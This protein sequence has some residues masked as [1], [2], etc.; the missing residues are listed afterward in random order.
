MMANSVRLFFAVDFEE[1]VRAE[2][3][4]IG[5]EI[6]QVFET[7]IR[8]KGRKWAWVSEKNFHLTV[9]F[10]GASAEERVPEILAAAERSLSGLRPFEIEVTGAGAFPRVLWVDIRDPS[11]RLAQVAS[12]IDLALEPLG[13]ARESSAFVPH[14][15][16]ARLKEGRPVQAERDLRPEWR[17]RSFGKSRIREVILYK[18]DTRPTGAVYE[19]VGRIALPEEFSGPS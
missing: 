17:E 15:T 4:R 3:A 5:L 19:P 10:L 9:K 12:A 18:S 14:L 6:R 7:E 2:V 11:T 8:L 1:K 13:F 16:V